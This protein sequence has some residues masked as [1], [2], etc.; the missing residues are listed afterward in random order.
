MQ[1]E[2]TITEAAAIEAKRLIEEYMFQGGT[3]FSVDL[4]EQVMDALGEADRIVI[5]PND[6]GAQ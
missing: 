2:I 5:V 3:G 1:T 6:E 4:L